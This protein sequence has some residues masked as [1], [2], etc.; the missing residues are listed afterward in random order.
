MKYDEFKA[1]IDAMDEEERKEHLKVFPLACLGG[2]I[3]PEYEKH[4]EAANSLEEFYDL[5]FADDDLR[6]T[7]IWAVIS[8][9]K[10]PSWIERFEY[11][12]VARRIKAKHGVPLIGENVGFSLFP[13]SLVGSPNV[14]VFE[15]AAFNEAGCEYYMAFT[16]KF[17]CVGIQLDGTYDVF[18]VGNNIIFEKW[19]FDTAGMRTNPRQNPYVG[20]TY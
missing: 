7:K 5:V 3:L 15:D 1:L 17:E 8:R 19:D 18:R 14:Y 9:M 4:A 6:F 11:V 16:G 12:D 2:S 20:H 10:D 13:A